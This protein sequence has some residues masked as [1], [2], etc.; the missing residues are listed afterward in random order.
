MNAFGYSGTRAAPVVYAGVA[1]P[2]VEW[3]WLGGRLGMRGR[4]WT[5][6]ER[7]SAYATAGDLL[8]T[9]QVRFRLGRVVELGVLAAGG[10]GIVLLEVN[11]VVSD[12]VVPRFLAEATVAFRIGNHFTLGPR[13][14]WGYFQW[15]SMNRYD[16]GMDLG[17]FFFGLGLEGR[18]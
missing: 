11:D 16:D 10:A 7:V 8:L 18:E 14:G 3:L 9:A 13:F 5:H 12:Q 6:P 15:E 4:Q 2:L 17:G 1:V